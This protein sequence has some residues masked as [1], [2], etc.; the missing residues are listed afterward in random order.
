MDK[1]IEE[2]KGMICP[3]SLSGSGGFQWKNCY[4]EKCMAWR[5]TVT[6]KMRKGQTNPTATV[7]KT[8]GYCGMREKN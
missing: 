8:R 2:A 5:W 6:H 4:G 1:T 3:M 7:S